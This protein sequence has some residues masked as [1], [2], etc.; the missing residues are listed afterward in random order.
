V[1]VQAAIVGGLLALT[2]GGAPMVDTIGTLGATA[3]G[4][5]TP[6]GGRAVDPAMFEPG[7]C[8]SY[9]PTSGNRHESVFLDAGH[10]SIDPGTIGVTEADQTIYEANE[11]LAVELD[12]LTLLRAQGFTVIVSRTRNS[13]VARPLSGDLS[14]GL[15]TL[16]G[17]LRDVASR[18]VCADMAKANILVGIYFE[19]GASTQNAGS[20]TG[21]DTDRPFAADNLRLGTL[22]Q[23]DVLAA[24]NAQG[25]GIPDD[26]V[27]SDTVLGGPPLSD[28]AANYDHLVLLGPADPGYFTTPSTMPGALIEPLF[29]T[30]PYEGTLANSALGQEVI[31]RGLATAIAQY[32]GPTTKVA[33]GPVKRAQ[34][35]SHKRA[36]ASDRTPN[37]HRSGASGTQT[38]T[39]A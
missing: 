19:A 33:T 23:T 16:Q 8:V 30:D 22:L 29:I 11:T 2:L 20:I 25:W 39:G 38:T 15:Y 26:G 31:A 18:D 28:A 32:F 4:A 14:D 21:Y 17:D 1:K 27:V 10:G 37:K 7:S 35:K 12:A 24:M 13:P 36:R 3:A 6:A 9:D 34:A 5:A